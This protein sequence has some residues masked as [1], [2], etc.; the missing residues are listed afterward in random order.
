[1]DSESCHFSSTQ[2]LLFLWTRAGLSALRVSPQWRRPGSPVWSERRSLCLRWVLP[3]RHWSCES[4][5]RTRTRVQ[6]LT[7]LTLPLPPTGRVRTSAPGKRHWASFMFSTA[8]KPPHVI[9]FLRFLSIRP[10]V[11]SVDVVESETHSDPKQLRKLRQQQLQQ[12]FRRE[13]EAKKLQQKQHRA[14]SE[15]AEV[16]VGQGSSGG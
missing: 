3:G 7:L 11:D 4:S 2:S 1:M 9:S 8:L 12:K 5:T 16:A 15:E 10:A 6:K 14:K 13:M